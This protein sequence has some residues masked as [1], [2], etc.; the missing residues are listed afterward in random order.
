MKRLSKIEKIDKGRIKLYIDGEY[1]G[2]LYQKEF[3]RFNLSEEDEIEEKVICEIA[4]ILYRRAKERAL[5]ILQRMDKTEKQIMD[6][7]RQN[8][9]SD[10]VIFKVIE[11]LRTYRFIDDC[12]YTANYVKY[13]EEKKSI[14]QLKQDLYKKGISSSVINDFFESYDSTEDIAIEK[15]IWKKIKDK[16]IDELEFKERD[17]L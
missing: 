10:A 2:F 13:K 5:Y 7:L 8:L 9:Y 16:K 6:K 14:R 12:R 3:K 1:L 4:D 11:F 15:L 17:R